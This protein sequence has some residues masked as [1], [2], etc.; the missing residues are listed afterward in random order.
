MKKLFAAGFGLALSFASFANSTTTFNYNGSTPTFDDVLNGEQSRTEYRTETRFTTCFRQEV[1]GSRQVCNG[2][3]GGYYGGAGYYGPYSGPYL[4]GYHGGYYGGYSRSIYAS[5]YS[6][7]IYRTVSY[8]CEETVKVPYTVKELDVVAKVTI[9]VANESDEV[10]NEAISV[11]LNNDGTVSLKATGSKNYLIF[12]TGKKDAATVSGSVKTINATYNVELIPATALRAT[13][14]VV[15]DASFTGVTF[16]HDVDV[17]GLMTRTLKVEKRRFLAKKKV[18]FDNVLTAKNASTL[19]GFAGASVDA[20]FANLG[21]DF[22][23][24]RYVFTVTSKVDTKGL[25]NASQFD[26]KLS[27]EVVLKKKLR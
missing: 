17:Y 9:N 24:G 14:V 4:G 10:A 20:K 18:L 26:G 8:T 11:T 7:P 22:K 6:E 3:A 2:G 19:V 27:Q 16:N 21:I 1:A 5:C 23:K 13:N 25:L 12:L 15:L